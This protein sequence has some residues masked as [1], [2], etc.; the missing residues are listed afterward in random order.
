MQNRSSEILAMRMRY[1]EA[2]LKGAGMGMGDFSKPFD[3]FELLFEG[4]GGMGSR[5]SRNRAVDG[6][7]EYYSLVL[8]FKE[9]SFGVEK[10]I[11]ISRLGTVGPAMVQVSYSDPILGTTI[12]VPTVDAWH[13]EIKWLIGLMTKS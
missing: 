2:G 9:A 6:Q 4:M 8:N 11:E 5:A 10:E 13:G 3:L 7:D 12:K 1:G